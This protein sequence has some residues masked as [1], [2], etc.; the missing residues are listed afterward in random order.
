MFFQLFVILTCL[1]LDVS[2][3]AR[4]PYSSVTR[5]YP[6]SVITL[7]HLNEDE[8]NYNDFGDDFSSSSSP[9]VSDESLFSSLRSRQSELDGEASR[10][11]FFQDVKDTRRET[12]F[13]KWKG[14]K[15]FSSIRLALPND[16]IRRLSLKKWPLAVV[17]GAR[18][19]LHLANLETGSV[20]HQVSGAH[21]GGNYGADN[22][23]SGESPKG[24]NEL[25]E[26]LYGEYGDGGGV[27]DVSIGGL[28]D[29]NGVATVGREGG[30][31]LW[32]IATSSDKPKTANPSI[33]LK[34]QPTKDKPQLIARGHVFKD[35]CISAIQY[36]SVGSL[37]VASFE[38]QCVYRIDSE[39]LRPRLTC[40]VDNNEGKNGASPIICL[41][42]ENEI[43]LLV[44]G[45][46]KGS[47]EFFQAETGTL[48]A[49]WHF[50]SK[51]GG[52]DAYPRSVAIVGSGESTNNDEEEWIVV[53]GMS[54]GSLY[55][56]RLRIN[57]E[58]GEIHHPNEEELF[59][60]EEA[61][62]DLNS[63][64]QA[65]V[66]SLTPHPHPKGRILVS[67]AHDGTLRVWDCFPE[68]GSSK[69]KLRPRC[70]YG[71]SGYKVWLGSVCI[72]DKGERLLS[73]GSDN[74]I[75]VHDFS[76][77]EVD[78]DDKSNLEQ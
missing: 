53:C 67:G 50:Q 19:D 27:M 33:K 36:D 29:G 60:P 3:F 28:G 25:K 78:I 35:E 12:I 44:A 6:P 18:G 21:E 71:F 51:D 8:N 13:S 62:I 55:M 32:R 31:K 74:T 49:T 22:G 61:T 46:V 72:D 45:T 7:L 43:N 47:V 37:W 52:N 38:K 24:L 73:D 23:E 10:L 76:S 69:K 64:H 9:S 26:Y 11:Q 56:R 66:V 68:I 58:T 48:L 39:E 41:A 77:A 57:D 15:A 63:S 54:D 1:S 16:Y 17:G 42:V 14:A 70:L 5:S 65:Q 20:V 4:L 40:C 59:F 75:I 34:T 30:V 2:A